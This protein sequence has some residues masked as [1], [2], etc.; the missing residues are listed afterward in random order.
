MLAD[1]MALMIC[2][3]ISITLREPKTDE[4]SE[5]T[6]HW[7]ES[8][9]IKSGSNSASVAGHALRKLQ[10]LED[11]IENRGEAAHFLECTNRFFF[12]FSTCYH[13][14]TICTGVV[15]H[16]GT[17]SS[18]LHDVPIADKA[19]NAIIACIIHHNA[20]VNPAIV[21][22]KKVSGMVF[23]NHTKQLTRSRNRF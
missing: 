5:D 15:S 11:L 18:L 13:S 17:G 19:V 12:C 14:L 4:V 1:I 16:A 2:D 8:P 21:L 22:A 6:E 7:L 9:V 10:F 3:R 23:S 20:R